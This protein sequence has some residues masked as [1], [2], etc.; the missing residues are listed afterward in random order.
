MEIRRIQG[1]G[2]AEECARLMSGTEP[3]ITLRRRYEQSL[4]V[5]TDPVLEIYGAFAEGNLVGF[6][7]IDMRG[8][9]VGYVKSL[10]VQPDWRNR[11]VGTRLMKFAEERIFPEVPN[12]FI[13]VS[14]FNRDAR[15]LYERLGYE[16]I[17]DLKEWVV[18]GHDETLLRKTRGPLSTFREGS[19]PS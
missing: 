13:C 2:E 3:W 15:R 1:Q 9:F 10:A 5:M 19:G 8:S 7:V 14:S 4:K 16:V 18:P 11:G 17:G 6:V 12:V